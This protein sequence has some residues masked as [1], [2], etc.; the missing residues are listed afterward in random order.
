MTDALLRRLRPSQVRELIAAASDSLSVWYRVAA[1]T[2]HRAGTL[3][4]VRWSDIDLEDGL[5][6]FSRAIA[7]GPDGL[8][9]KGTKADR[10][11]AVT[12]DPHTVAALRAHRTRMAER[13][14]SA[15]VALEGDAFVW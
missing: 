7:R 15:G 10:A 8:V 5:V 2:G 6:V 13:A 11:D 12:L 9:E 1:V 3:A 14:L 4:A